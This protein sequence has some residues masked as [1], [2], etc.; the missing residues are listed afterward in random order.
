MKGTRASLAKPAARKAAAMILC[1]VQAPM[2]RVGRTDWI[3]AALMLVSVVCEVESEERLRCRQSW[4]KPIYSD[5]IHRLR[6]YVADAAPRGAMDVFR[7]PCSRDPSVARCRKVL[8]PS[9]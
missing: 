3:E 1:N 2:R 6:R 8:T 4:Q 5:D 7:R 9:R